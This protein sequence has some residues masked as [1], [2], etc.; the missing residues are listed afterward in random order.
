M[1]R[2]P[3]F[4][5]IITDQQ[6]ADHLGCYGN[7]I[8]RTPNIDRLASRGVRATE[9]YTVSPIC[10]PSRA[11]LQTGRMPSVHGVRHNGIEL[12]TG[13]TT[14]VDALRLA[15]YQTA[16]AGKS[17]LQCI[18]DV[19]PRIP[20][21]PRQR[22][23]REA[24]PR[25]AGVYHQE[26]GHKW[27]TDP[28]HDLTY[29]Y[30]GFEK[31]HLSIEHGDDQY[32]HW[33]RW[34]RQTQRDADKLIG[35]ENAEPTPEIELFKYRQAWRTRV[36]E[37]LYPTR[38]I[39]DRTID[40]VREFA[41][42]KAPFFIQCAFPDPHHPF[43]PPGKYWGM[44]DATDVELPATFN[45]AHI[46]PPA[47]LQSLWDARDAGKA[48]KHTSA[49]FA[50][51]EREAREAIS[52]NYGLITQIDDCVG[53]ILDEVERLGIS[54]NT[55]VVFTSDHADYMGEHQLLL[56]GPMH[57]RGLCRVPFIWTDPQ[58]GRART[59]DALIQNIDFAPTVLAR[60][61]VAPWHGIQGKS[62]LPILAEGKD[63]GYDSIL[64]EEE[65]QRRPHGFPNR[66]KV[67]TLITR[68]HRLSIFAGVTWGE[69][70]DLEDDPHECINR[71]NDPGARRAKAEMLEQLARRMMDYAET[72]PYP[73]FIA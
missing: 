17:H 34:L 61:G 8:V 55:V 69:L 71:W 50:A 65:S 53:R 63:G 4:I 58:V 25:A 18:L 21:D 70:Y 59:V 39:A 26:L 40:L 28:A 10:M 20:E 42:G 37:E 23:E 11:S 43:T 45:A 35:Y 1:Q 12:S 31:V 29:P 36:P 16:L 46:N 73:D 64:I 56:K 3:N 6:R 49:P 48:V 52:L 60:A 14:L 15:G 2:R 47:P 57:Y 9:C 19:P 51:T 5:F 24:R 32:G 67:R 68:T 7:R 44:Y 62:L 22:L 38:W 27:E 66:V 72:S 13:E 41:R 30:Y 33:R 54:G